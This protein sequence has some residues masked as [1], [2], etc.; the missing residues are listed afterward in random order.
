[1]A[2]EEPSALGDLVALIARAL[3]DG[4]SAAEVIALAEA[5]RDG[6]K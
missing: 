3:D 5:Q 6:A 1:M 2:S 4:W